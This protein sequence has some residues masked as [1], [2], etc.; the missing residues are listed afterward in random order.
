MLGLSFLP[1]VIVFRSIVIAARAIVMNLLSAVALYGMLVRMFQN[2]NLT[3]F[4]GFQQ[5][6]GSEALLLLF[7]VSILYGL[8]MG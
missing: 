8:S 2:G 6:G 7:P 3:G 5:V 4:F 1:L